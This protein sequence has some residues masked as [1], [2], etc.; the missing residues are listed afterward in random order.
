MF[1]MYSSLAEF[2]GR[3]NDYTR[4]GWKVH[5]WNYYPDGIPLLVVYWTRD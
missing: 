5:S 3:C 1:L 4:D 2:N